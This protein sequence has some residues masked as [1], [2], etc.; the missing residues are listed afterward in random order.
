M[1]YVHPLY[2]G[3]REIPCNIW[4]A[5]L[6]GCSDWP[7]RM[8]SAQWKPGL[9]FTEMVK[10]DA[11]V[12]ADEGT[13]ELLNYSDCMHPI[14]AQVFG[15]NPRYA[16]EAAPI[17]ESMGFDVIDLNCGCPVDKVTKGG[18]GS[19]LLKTPFLIGDIVSSIVGAVQ[20][21]VTVKVRAGWDHQH[22]NIEEVVSI[23]E[24]AGAKAITVHGRTR[25]QGYTGSC[26]HEWIKRAKSA[27]HNIPV[28]G[29]GDVFSAEDAFTMMQNTGCD[30]VLIARG[31]MGK[32]WFV[33]DIRRLEQGLPVLQ[34]SIEELRELLLQH[35][36]YVVEYKCEKKALMDARR[37]GGWYVNSVKGAKAF[38]IAIAQVQSIE[39]ARTLI[40]TFP[41]EPL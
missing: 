40:K 32:P 4:Y 7:Y 14:G 34:F 2:L 25:Q 19:G 35:F 6:A 26:C 33:E 38:R 31:G 1:K 28:I 11:L 41:F 18:G 20:I 5:P 39:E 10:M 21:P 24:S 29:N 16:K 13:Y 9:Q 30:G 36:N 27:A 22:I 37:I 8:M 12:R 23:V 3:E 17:L 15:S